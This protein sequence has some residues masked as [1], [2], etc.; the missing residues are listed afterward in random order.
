M[1]ATVGNL[2][3]SYIELLNS[4]FEILRF[5]NFLWISVKSLFYVGNVPNIATDVGKRNRKLNNQIE[6]RPSQSQRLKASN[7]IEIARTEDYL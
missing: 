3:I 4:V 7:Y 5:D 2:I 1:K 6:L